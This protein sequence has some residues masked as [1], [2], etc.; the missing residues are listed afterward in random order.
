[1]DDHMF[2]RVWEYGLC[3]LIPR[4]QKEY[5][6]CNSMTACPSYK[7]IK[8]YCKVLNLLQK[9]DYTRNTKTPYKPSDL[10]CIDC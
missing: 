3:E 10:L 7:E 4:F 8:D 5:K 9:W 6:E 2:D 1:M